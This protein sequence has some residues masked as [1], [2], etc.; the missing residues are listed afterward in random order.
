MLIRHSNCF[1]ERSISLHF[2][3]LFYFAAD[4][5]GRDRN[6]YRKRKKEKK[7][8]M[9]EKRRKKSEMW[10]EKLDEHEANVMLNVLPF[11]HYDSH[12]I[13]FHVMEL[14]F[15]H[16]RCTWSR[17]LIFDGWAPAAAQDVIQPYGTQKLECW[18][19]TNSLNAS[20][21]ASSINY[22]IVS[23]HIFVLKF[24][25]RRATK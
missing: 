2:W 14:L 8:N 6:I 13:Y 20:F 21:F 4:F 23:L 10:L 16:H 9:L 3:G 15:D 19:H 7:L 18:L 24:F 5:I 11:I 17:S 22:S 25:E 12:F 1:A